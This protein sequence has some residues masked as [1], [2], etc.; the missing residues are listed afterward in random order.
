MV[1]IKALGGVP[2]RTFAYVSTLLVLATK[3]THK[4]CEKS[5]LRKKNFELNLSTFLRDKL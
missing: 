1:R 2:N 5:K 4:M 3:E